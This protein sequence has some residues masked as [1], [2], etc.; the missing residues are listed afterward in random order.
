MIE[1][2]YQRY[3][4]ITS[5]KYNKH[6]LIG[7]LATRYADKIIFPHIALWKNMNVLE[8][9][10][11]SGKYTKV[12]MENNCNVLGIDM[13]PHL[14]SD[15]G[16]RVIK[17]KADK[18]NKHLEDESFDLA[19]SFWLSEY[20]NP[21]ELER[22]FNECWKVLK[23]GGQLIFTVVEPIWL[24]YLYCMGARFRGIRK[25]CYDR[26]WIFRILS[27]N[28]NISASI[29]LYGTLGLPFAILYE[30]KKNE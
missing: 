8:V 29:N 5:K 30:A 12:F 7:L 19:C 14:F 11:G 2:N 10:L 3:K 25:Y 27:K 4:D 6:S 20:L 23:P 17:A 22:Y 13:N 24:G 28:Y 15:S 16:V 1:K 9:G 18:F 26:D 21:K